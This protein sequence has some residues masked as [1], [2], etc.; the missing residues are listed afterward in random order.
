[1]KKYIENF[2]KSPSNLHPRSKKRKKTSFNIRSDK[3]PRP[4]PKKKYKKT[5][6]KD[7]Y[8]KSGR[9]MKFGN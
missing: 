3:I 6:I 1:V 9:G 2:E 7:L 8:R 4:G 5:K